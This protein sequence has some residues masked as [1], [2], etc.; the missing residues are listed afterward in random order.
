MTSAVIIGCGRMGR[1]HAEAYREMGV[2]IIGVADID[3][4]KALL[5]AQEFNTV[6]TE[7][8]EFN[9]DHMLMDGHPLNPGYV[10]VCS[11]DDVHA[12]QI[13]GALRV[14]HT[15]IAEKPLCLTYEDLERI[16]AIKTGKLVCNLPLRFQVSPAVQK[17]YHI[18]ADYLWGRSDQLNGWRKNCPGYSFVLG[19]GIH[20]ADA[21]MRIMGQRATFVHAVAQ[22]AA[23]FPAPTMISAHGSFEDG[24]TFRIDINCAYTANHEYR[25]CQWGAH[26]KTETHGWASNKRRSI[27]D[28]ITYPNRVGNA[29]IGAHA[30]CFAIER[31][32]INKRVEQVIYP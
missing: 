26:G 10:S 31:S 8:F 24:K 29:G 12:L 28:A 9:P 6:A 3:H 22:H 17:P 7:Y 11:W 25:I 16:N 2:P 4:D 21:A 5:F 32:L 27:H 18:E 14:G 20:V 13:I 23:D 1:E 30:L 19:G 15:V